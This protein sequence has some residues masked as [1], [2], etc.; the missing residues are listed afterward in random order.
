MRRRFCISSRI[1]SNT[2]LNFVSAQVIV[3][4]AQHPHRTRDASQFR[5]A[6]SFETGF[7]HLEQ[8][9]KKAL[10]RIPNRRTGC[11]PR[12][13][14]W[15]C[16]LCSAV[17]SSQL[18]AKASRTAYARSTI[19]VVVQNFVHRVF[20]PAN[21]FL[22]VCT[23]CI[24]VPNDSYRRCIQ[25]NSLNKRRSSFVVQ[26]TRCRIPEEIRSHCPFCVVDFLD[27]CQRHCH[28]PKP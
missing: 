1:R 13:S 25:L 3:C 23:V 4:Q 26:K 21:A 8:K 10:L 2:L 22:C 9:S 15:G 14:C 5:S 12:T 7:T 19:V 24:C 27:S 11:C 6:Q 20:Y 16:V 18:T 28:F 17:P